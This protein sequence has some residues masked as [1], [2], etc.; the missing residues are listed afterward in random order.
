MK[1]Q[2]VIWNRLVSKQ[3]TIFFALVVFKE[4]SAWTNINIL[5][6]NQACANLCFSTNFEKNKLPQWLSLR[7]KTFEITILQ[8][9]KLRF[10]VS[11][12]FFELGILKC[13]VL[14]IWVNRAKAFLEKPT[15]EAWFLQKNIIRISLSFTN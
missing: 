14:S 6:S 5:I 8:L 2:S 7:R 11:N 9:Q 3:P 15:T 1:K 13:S 4:T 10:W 12:H